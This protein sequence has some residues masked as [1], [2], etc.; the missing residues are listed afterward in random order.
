MA[1]SLCGLRRGIQAGD[2]IGRL[3]V[4][5]TIPC[6]VDSYG[7]KAHH[8]RCACGTE[9][10]TRTSQLLHGGAWSCGCLRRELAPTRLPAARAAAMAMGCIP[11]DAMGRFTRVED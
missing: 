2:R 9:T 4:L 7:S 6:Y 5:N 11:R 8:C 10:V 3:T 1:A